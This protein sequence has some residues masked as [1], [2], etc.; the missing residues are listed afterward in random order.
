MFKVELATK[1]LHTADGKD[2]HEESNK[3]CNVDNARCCHNDNPED[4][5]KRSQELDKPEDT[6]QPSHPK[7]SERGHAV[8]V[9]CELDQSCDDYERVKEI[10]GVGRKHLLLCGHLCEYLERE[11]QRQVEVDELQEVVILLGDT[12]MITR[13]RD[14]VD[15][16][17]CHERPREE[18]RV[19][20][21][22]QFYAPR[23]EV[24]YVE[25]LDNGVVVRL[26][27]VLH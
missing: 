21:P 7:D 23:R 27:L 22:M 10:E 25:R 9:R 12:V 6:Q 2:K 1:E 17:E 4:C 5:T 26:V 16:D 14:G 19:Y 20:D 15:K 3:D 8:A 24:C 18:M 11:D 13:Q